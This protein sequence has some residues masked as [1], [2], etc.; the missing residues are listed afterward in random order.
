MIEAIQKQLEDRGFSYHPRST[1]DKEPQLGL[2]WNVV[3]IPET[4]TGIV[5]IGR[6][7][8]LYDLFS[9]TISQTLQFIENFH[10]KT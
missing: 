10:N 4:E 1:K 5:I 8:G 7:D 9:G 2:G 6:K 3:I